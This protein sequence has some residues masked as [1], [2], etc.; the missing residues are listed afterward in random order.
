MTGGS[1]GISGVWPSPWLSG[2][3][4]YYT[5]TLLLVGAAVL[6][7][8]RML[9]SPFGYAMRAGRDSPLRADAIGIAVPRV[10]W[11]A[12]TGAATLVNSF[13]RLGLVPTALAVADPGRLN[14]DADSWGSYY[15]Q[16]PQ[17][18]VG[19]IGYGHAALAR[20]GVF[21]R[22]GLPA[23]VQEAGHAA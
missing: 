15:A 12:F 19:N 10:Q 23:S 11:V 22:L 16:H 4:S 3:Q 2:R 21:E 18:F 5:L 14:G 6:L 17:V 7:M 20:G 1:N 13:H 9:F 8:R